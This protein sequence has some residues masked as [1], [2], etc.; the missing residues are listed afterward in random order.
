M[1][2]HLFNPENDLA[3]ADGNANYC[4][5][6]SALKI[7]YDLSTLPLWY[8]NNEDAVYLSDTS[9]FEYYKEYSK[10]FIL[11]KEILAFPL[12]LKTISSNLTLHFKIM[13]PL[14]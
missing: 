3:I 10:N 11:P 5:P 1:K 7:A 14:K 13:F 9:H 4:A 8:A 2:L 6:P 12:F